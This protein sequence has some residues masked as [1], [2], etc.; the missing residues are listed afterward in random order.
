[1]REA[2]WFE[3]RVWWAGFCAGFASAMLAFAILLA[4]A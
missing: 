1:M 3:H 4:V 2:R